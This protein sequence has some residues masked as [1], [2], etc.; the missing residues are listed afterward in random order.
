M[1]S[2]GRDN[3]KIRRGTFILG[4]PLFVYDSAPIITAGDLDERGP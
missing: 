4:H 1:I 3:R 2:F